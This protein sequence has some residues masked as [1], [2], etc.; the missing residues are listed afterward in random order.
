MTGSPISADVAT[1]VSRSAEV[2]GKRPSSLLFDFDGTLSELVDDPAEARIEARAEAAL[3]QL[4]GLVDVVA[5][6]TGRAVEDVQTKLDTSE[7]VVVGNH[8]LEWVVRGRHDAHEAGVAAEAAVSA[9]VEEIRARLEHDRLTDGVIF[10]N[11]RL[12]ASVHYRMAPNQKQVASVLIPLARRVA[13]AHGLRPTEGKLIV[14]L[15]PTAEVSKGTAMHQLQQEFGLASMVFLGD[16]LTDVDG[17]L[18]LREMRETR[19]V[20]SLAVGVLGHDSHPSVGETA[21][22]AVTEVRGVA[23]YLEQLVARLQGS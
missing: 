10:E 6:V 18:S 17:F 4:T 12:S 1:A 2:L 15:R 9:A 19:K 3:H 11:K 7:L 16:D 14:E 22:V 13:A 21:D 5:I 8:G 20:E 23:D